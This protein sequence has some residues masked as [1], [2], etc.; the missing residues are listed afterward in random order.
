MR[1]SEL[2][3][4]IVVPEATEL[5]KLER[6]SLVHYIYIGKPIDKYVPIYG[7]KPTIQLNDKIVREDNITNE[8]PLFIEQHKLKV[9]ENQH[10]RITSSFR[11]DGKV[12]MGIV[13]DVKTQL[14][15]SGQL[16]VNY[17]ARPRAHE[18]DK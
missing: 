3:L 17:S 13:Q 16:R 1:S 11:V 7:T 4:K 12:T 9:P 8:I 2:K 14:R 15:K 18:L 10:G 6:K 5:T